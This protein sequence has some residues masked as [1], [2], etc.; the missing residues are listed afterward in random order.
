M[1]IHAEYIYFLICAQITVCSPG[2]NSRSLP[3]LLASVLEEGLAWFLVSYPYRAD[4]SC[5]AGIDHT[6]VEKYLPYSVVDCP[7][8]KIP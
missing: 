8:K 5:L 6:C 1:V 2:V 3:F 4:H 7:L